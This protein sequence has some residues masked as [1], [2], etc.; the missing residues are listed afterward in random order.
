MKHLPS[1]RGVWAAMTKHKV[2]PNPKRSDKLFIHWGPAFVYCSYFL[3]K[4]VSNYSQ[5]LNYFLTLQCKQIL[6]SHQQTFQY[7]ELDFYKSIESL[8]HYF[9]RVSLLTV[10]SGIANIFLQFLSDL[11]RFHF[12]QNYIYLCD[13]HSC[14]SSHC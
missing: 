12:Y 3:T 4:L 10:L 11:R 6:R 14:A 9:P 13:L 8:S 7:V 5:A 2:P 1:I